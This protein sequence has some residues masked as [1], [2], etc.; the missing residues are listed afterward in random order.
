MYVYHTSPKYETNYKQKQEITLENK[1]NIKYFKNSLGRN[2]TGSGIL[3]TVLNKIPLPEM[4]MSLP[5]HISSEYVPND[6]F[7]NTQKYSFC[8][9]KT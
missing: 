2:K 6:S 4:H 9:P 1:I 8:G 5:Y 3:N 7:N